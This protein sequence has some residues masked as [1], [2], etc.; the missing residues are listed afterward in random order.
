MIRQQQV[1]FILCRLSA[2]W[3][4]GRAARWAV[5]ALPGPLIGIACLAP[6]GLFPGL[7]ASL[8]ACLIV[9]LAAA[10]TVPV[11]DALRLPTPPAWTWSWRAAW[12]RLGGSMATT[13]TVSVAFALVDGAAAL[14]SNGPPGR[15]ALDTVSLGERLAAVGVAVVAL[16]G[17]VPSTGPITSRRVGQRPAFRWAVYVAIT[18]ALCGGLAR[19]ITS[20]PAAGVT[21]ALSW[22][23]LS[24]IG[25]WLVGTSGPAERVSWSWGGGPCDRRCRRCWRSRPAA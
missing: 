13:V 20:G 16:S 9:V 10:V 17:V 8:R 23:L 18:F 4:Q 12:A 1:V 19:A 22:A 15:L 5:D 3:L 25:A 7:Y 2:D 11:L 6:W 21:L 24:G 14:D